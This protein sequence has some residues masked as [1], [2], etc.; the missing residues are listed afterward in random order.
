MGLERVRFLF[1]LGRGDSLA[2]ADPAET[3]NFGFVGRSAFDDV[4]SARLWS[5]FAGLEF[6]V[7]VSRFTRAIRSPRR[8]RKQPQLCGFIYRSAF[9]DCSDQFSSGPYGTILLI[10]DP[11][12][13]GDLLAS[14][15][16]AQ[17]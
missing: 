7:S 17:N 1:Q 10:S 11:A 16:F 13:P 8:C 2:E 5:R 15:R 3:Q 9:V 12:S 14:G 4:C 6:V